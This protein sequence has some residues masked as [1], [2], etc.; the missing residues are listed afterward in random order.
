MCFWRASL[1]VSGSGAYMTF[2][3]ETPSPT[4]YF[5]PH[6]GY[7]RYRDFPGGVEETRGRQNAEIPETPAKVMRL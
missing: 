2:G 7:A 5:R 6:P 1:V 4:W 3:V